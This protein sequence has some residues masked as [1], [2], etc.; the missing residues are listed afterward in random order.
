[1]PVARGCAVIHSMENRWQGRAEM[2]AWKK[3]GKR[4]SDGDSRAETH[5]EIRQNAAH[6]VPARAVQGVRVTVCVCVC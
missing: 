1:M 3:R 2:T 5:T 6:T 4:K